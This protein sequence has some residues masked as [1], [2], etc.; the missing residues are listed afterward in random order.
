MSHMRVK[1]VYLGVV[2]H[3][4]GRKEEEYELSEGSSFKDLLT[5]IVEAHI[6][7]KDLAGSLNDSQIDPTLIATLNGF[8]VNLNSSRNIILKDGDTLTLMTVIGGG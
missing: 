5:K 3:K 4:V 6:A 2:R 8:A 7:L 1:V